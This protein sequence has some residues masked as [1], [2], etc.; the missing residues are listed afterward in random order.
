MDN[1]QPLVH[2]LIVLLQDSDFHVGGTVDVVSRYILVR[3]PAN[4]DAE[5]CGPADRFVIPHL[6]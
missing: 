5:L 2:D 6:W 4:V 3:G 1:K